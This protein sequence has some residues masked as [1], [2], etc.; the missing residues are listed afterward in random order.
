MVYSVED[1]TIAAVDSEGRI[2]GLSEGVTTLTATML[3]S[4][5]STSVRVSVDGAR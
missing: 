1:P 2:T 3:P 4:G 5:R